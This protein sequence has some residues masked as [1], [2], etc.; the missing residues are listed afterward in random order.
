MAQAQEQ[1]SSVRAPVFRTLGISTSMN[2]AQVKA[3]RADLAQQVQGVQRVV[4]A[5][6]A[7]S[8]DDPE[9]TRLSAAAVP[10]LD[11]YLKRCD[12]SID[13]GGVTVT[14]QHVGGDHASDS[15]V[16]HIPQD[17]V[18]FVGDCLC[19]AIYT[20]QRFFTTAALYP[21]LDAVLAFDADITIEGH[22][23][24]PL[25]RDDLGALAAKLRLAGDAVT[26]SDGD[27]AAALESIRMA[28]GA[29]A[30]NDD[31]MREFAGLFAAGWRA[32]LPA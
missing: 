27:T 1:L 26:T 29:A 13:L 22:A 7:R 32:E 30:V 10:L 5:M 20:P 2:D 24:T 4:G 21:L 17:G 25:T 11:Q 6:P 23:D 8:G 28:H 3:V 12:K 18:L 16:M 31:D 14:L 9:V 19:E 15:V